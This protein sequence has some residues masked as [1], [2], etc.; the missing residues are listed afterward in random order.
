MKQLGGVLLVMLVGCHTQPLGILFP[1]FQSVPANINPS[2]VLQC[3]IN[4]SL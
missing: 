2:E 4:S 3:L 1:F